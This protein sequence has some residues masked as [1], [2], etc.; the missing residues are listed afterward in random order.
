MNAILRW[1]AVVVILVLIQ[2]DTLMQDEPADDEIPDAV[3]FDDF[4]YR[5]NDD[6][7][8]EHGWV[9][10]TAGGWPG[11]P[12]A[13]WWEDGVRFVR[14]PDDTQNRLVQMT[15]KTDGTEENTHQVQLCYQRKF[16]E[17]TYAARIRF[18]DEPAYGPDGDQIV[19]TFYTIS[20]LAFDLDPDYSEMDFEYL[21]NG[22]WGINGSVLF[23]VTWES[24]RPE[25]NWLAQN[26]S[27][28][29]FRSLDGWHIL[30]FQVMDGEVAY[31]IDGRLMNIH[32]DEY[33]PE[34]PVSINF[35]QWFI[36]DGLVDSPEERAYVEQIDWVLHAA[37][38]ALMPDDIDALIQVLRDDKIEFLD[39][40]LPFDPPLESPCDL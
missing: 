14:D 19:Q 3:F 34:V 11:V 22:G 21:P 37:N 15:S 26:T 27:S 2:P 18:S 8:A 17:G 31:F 39:T 40:I 23:A 13:I 16:L 6:R 10:R 35:N 12:G 33:Y 9:V 25:P 24:F 7:F 1:L 28:S 5:T 29:R 38:T 32:A 36:R 4:S 20:P 30:A